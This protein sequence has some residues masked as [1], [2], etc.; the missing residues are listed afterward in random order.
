MKSLLLTNAGGL[1]VQGEQL[2]SALRG[3]SILK[4]HSLSEPS[5]V[6][7]ENGTISNY[8]AL[9]QAPSRADQVIDLEGK[10]VFPGFV[11]SHTHTV[12][13]GSREHEMVAR[14]QGQSYQ[15]IALAGGGILNSAAKLQS[16][17]ED[18][19]FE[20][21]YV[22]IQR[23]IAKGT[24][25][26]EI[27]SGYGLSYE[28]ELKML[29]VI[30]R[31]KDAFSINIF[32]SLLAAHA[33]PKEYAQDRTGY[34]SM[35]TD[36]LIPEVADQGLADFVDV[37]CEKI[38][39]SAAETEQILEAGQKHELLGKIHSNQFTSIGGIEAAIK[40]GA[41]SVDHLEHLP[42]HDI[43]LLGQS[44]IVSTLLP[45]AAFFLSDPMPPARKLIDAG[46][47]IA[48][49]TDYNP[50]SSPGYSMPFIMTLACIKMS[51]TPQS[52]LAAMTIN[53]AAS[54]DQAARLGSITKGKRADLLITQKMPSLAYMAYSFSEDHIEQ[55]YAAGKRIH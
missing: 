55:V 30:R 6:L 17:S 35:I 20:A 31:L 29:R 33:L 22:R 54:L 8:G 1:F 45:Q 52:A 21:A 23:I 49:A 3:A 44:D 19:L 13:A 48:L 7:I 51:M 18:E 40:Y 41:L 38:A 43:D 12:F 10:F 34:I 4:E 5:F 16:M 28:A 24:T 46:A 32:A 15:E 26:L 36:R 50:G 53:A 39:F 9:D 47:T 25:T 14:S 11:D 27:K 2:V 42:Q 37:F